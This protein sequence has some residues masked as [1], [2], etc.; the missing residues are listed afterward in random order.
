MNWVV[1]NGKTKQ[2]IFGFQEA[3]GE[4]A[5]PSEIELMVMP[6]L[7]VDVQGHRLGRGG[8]YYDRQLEKLS[9]DLKTV[10]VV[11]DSEILEFIPTEEHDKTVQFAVSPSKTLRFIKLS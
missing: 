2:G 5:D 6:A 1:F 4:D 7:A 10:A 3:T 11:F 9:P 8:G